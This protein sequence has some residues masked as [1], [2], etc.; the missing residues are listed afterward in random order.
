MTALIGHYW[1]GLILA[2]LIGTGT[3]WWIWGYRPMTELVDLDPQDALLDWP[4]SEPGASVQEDPAPAWMAPAPLADAAQPI[5]SDTPLVETQPD[6]PDHAPDDFMMIKGFNPEL[7][8]LLRSLGVNRFAQIA[9]W[10]PEDIERINDR[11]GVYRGR[12]LIDEWIGQ[13]RLLAKGD[14][15]TFNQ[16]YGH[17]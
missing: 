17:L 9:A 5:L 7:E 13:A 11:L 15:A 16:R 1:Y 12:I 6:E 10:M 3:G 8:T 14:M 4:P 2:L